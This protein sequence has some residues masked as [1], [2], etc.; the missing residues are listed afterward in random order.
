MVEEK[1]NPS[2]ETES[3]TIQRLTPEVHIPKAVLDDLKNLKHSAGMPSRAA[4]AYGL[5]Q[6]Y[7]HSVSQAQMADRA[8]IR[9]R[10]F[11]AGWRRTTRNKSA[12]MI[13]ESAPG[14]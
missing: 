8:E 3:E 14:V 4:R 1:R 5:L 11:S 12:M 7:G 13:I 2:D 10:N 6:A 9:L